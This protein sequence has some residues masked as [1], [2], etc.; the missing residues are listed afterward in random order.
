MHISSGSK[1]FLV[2]LKKNKNIFSINSTYYDKTTL[3]VIDRSECARKLKG[4]SAYFY[5][6]KQISHLWRYAQS[7]IDYM[8]DMVW[9]DKEEFYTC[10]NQADNAQLTVENWKIL[11]NI[12]TGNGIPTY[13]LNDRETGKTIVF[14]G[15]LNYEILNDMFIELTK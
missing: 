8:I 14:H 13:V 12:F 4:N 10:I 6:I 9:W 7:D 11:T 5:F 15:T 1:S 3:D 2:D